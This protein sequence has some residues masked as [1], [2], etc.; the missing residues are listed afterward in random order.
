MVGS[1]QAA[2][3]NSSSYQKS[4][5]TA[6]KLW[7]TF[8]T[9]TMVACAILLTL[10][11]I[12]FIRKS[13]WAKWFLLATIMAITSFIALDWFEGYIA[14]AKKDA[15]RQAIKETVLAPI[16]LPGRLLKGMFGFGK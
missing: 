9:P 1:T 8:R 12:F 15:I 13:S 4:A 11:F 14:Q 6:I 7:C 16:Q 2:M 10:T 5:L 3:G